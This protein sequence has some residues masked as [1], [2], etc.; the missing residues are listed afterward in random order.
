[1]TS[2]KLEQ[3]HVVGDLAGEHDR[4]R[5]GIRGGPDALVEP[6]AAAPQ[7]IDRAAPGRVRAEGPALRDGG[8]EKLGVHRHR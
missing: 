3:R 1:M 8:V 2:E 6:A 5:G 7:R 4:D